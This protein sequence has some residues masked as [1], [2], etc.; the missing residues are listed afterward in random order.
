MKLIIDDSVYELK[1]EQCNIILSATKKYI[2]RGIYAVEKDGVIE[3]KMDKYP[4]SERLR[5]AIN[6]FKENGFKVYYNGFRKK[7]RGLNDAATS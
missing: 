5:I 2:K 7:G 1:R 4:S 3:L 6:K